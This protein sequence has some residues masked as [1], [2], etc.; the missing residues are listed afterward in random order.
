MLA[1]LER[2][3]EEFLKEFGSFCLQMENLQFHHYPPQEWLT[4]KGH[5]KR[6]VIKGGHRE[7]GN[8]LK[9]FLQHHCLS[10][11]CSCGKAI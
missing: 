10:P 9:T 5:R 4:N 2:V 7:L 11:V 8:V 6:C 3:T 1:R